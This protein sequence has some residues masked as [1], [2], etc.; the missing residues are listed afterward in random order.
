M[1]TTMKT[2]QKAT[3]TKSE[4]QFGRPLI[5][6]FLEGNS[7]GET[8]DQFQVNTDLYLPEKHET[9]QKELVIPKFVSSSHTHIH[10]YTHIQ[11]SSLSHCEKLT[12]DHFEQRRKFDTNQ[13]IQRRLF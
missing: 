6:Y 12:I 9:M 2:P 8:L 5:P 13:R 11:L 1:T 4:P 10:T 7:D 3:P